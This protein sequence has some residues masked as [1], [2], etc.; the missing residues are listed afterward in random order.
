MCE[1]IV[2]SIVFIRNECKERE[3]KG[4]LTKLFHVVHCVEK[5]AADLEKMSS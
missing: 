3:T 4:N 2:A 1:F 5:R